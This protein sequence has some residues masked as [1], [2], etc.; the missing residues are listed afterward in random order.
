MRRPL[1]LTA[2]LLGFVATVQ[3]G[4]RT[5][6]NPY[7]HQFGA[8]GKLVLELKE[9][10]KHP[11]FWW[12]R[13]LLDY[14]VD[15]TG[16]GVEPGQLELVNRADGKPVPF[17][18]SD[19]QSKG[20]LLTSAMVSFFSDLPSGASRSFELRKTTSKKEPAPADGVRIDE[21]PDAVVVD[22]GA[23]KVRIPASQPLT[24]GAGVPGPLAA[25]GDT[26][27]W[28][29]QATLISPHKKVQTITTRILDRGPLFARVEVTYSFEGGATYT[30]TIRA[31]LGYDF[32]EFFEQIDGLAKE[33]NVFVE[34]DWKGFHATHRQGGKPIDKPYTL[35]FRGE[36]P[37]FTGPA[38]IENPAEDFYYRL[39]PNAADGTISVKN[40]DFTDAKSGRGIG[41]AVLDAYKWN[42]REYAIW[43]AGDAQAVRFRYA[44]GRLVWRWPIVSGTRDTA[45]LAYD[46]RALNTGPAGTATDLEPSGKS[47]SNY[48]AFVNSR[49][50]GMSLNLV[51]DWQLS[52]PDGAKLPAPVELPSRGGKPMESADAYLKALWSDSEPLKAEGN[53]VHP[54]GLRIMNYWVV[55]GFNKWRSKMSPEDRERVTALLLLTSYIA[56]RDETS[57]IVFRLGGHPNF[58]GDWKYPLMAGSFLFPDHPLANEWADQFEKTLEVMG[59]FYSRPEVK[60]W[61]AKGGR[62]TESIA[63]YNWAFIEPM[64]LANQLG[65]LFDGRDRWPNPGLARHGEYLYGITT[66]PVKL[67]KNGVPL[68]VA[69]G[70]ELT[71]ENGFQRIHPAQGA[72][73]GRRAI[74]RTLG[75]FGESLLRYRPLAGEYLLWA[76]QRPV[77]PAPAES[78]NDHSQIVGRDIPNKGTNPR[79]ASEKFT[80]YGI[81][82]R[83]AVDTP[84]EISVFLQQIDKGPNYRWGFGNEG[85]CG[86]IYYY[87]GGKSYA[88][89]FGED[90]GDR[91]VSDAELTANTGVYRDYTFKGIGM[92]DLTEPFYNLGTAQFAEI[93]PRQGPD[94]YSWPEYGGRSVLLAG[95]DYI[96]TYDVLNTQSR[97]AWNTIQG[98]DEKPTIIPLRG[99]NAYRINLTSK[100]KEDTA[101]ADRI[102]CYKGVSDRMLVVSHRK[103]LKAVLPG[104]DDPKAPPK[105]LTPESTDFIFQN[106]ENF[107]YAGQGLA[108]A[109]RAGLIRQKKDGRT[110]FA[111]FHGSLIGTDALKVSVDNPDLGISASFSKPDE[112]EGTFFSRKGGTLTLAFAQQVP[113]KTALYVD[114]KALASKRD[115]ETLTAELPAGKH[116]W[117]FTAGPA[118]PSTPQILNTIA[119]AGGATLVLPP[120]A[121]GQIHIIERSDDNGKTWTEAGR[122]ASQEFVLKGVKAPSKLHVR[123]VTLNLADPKNPRASLPGHDYPVYVT[124]KPPEPPEG[125]RLVLEKDAVHATWGEILGAKEYVLK[126]RVKGEDAWKQVH[127]TAG[128]GFT[129]SASGVVPSSAVP[130]LQAAASANSAPPETIYEYAVAAVDGNGEGPL[131]KIA[132][133]DPSSWRNWNPATPLVFKRQSAYWQPPYVRPDQVPPPAYPE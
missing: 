83:S 40:A 118:R 16:A 72:H 109:G 98:Q 20:G 65:I 85:G 58:M 78:E 42:D 30:G 53:W 18:L 57:P 60:S 28:L 130:G 93:L 12:P 116:D 37:F 90:T 35:F 69:S 33:D 7:I 119:Q 102:D 92:N 112:V 75:D 70:T 51:K 45:V 68:D 41:I 77:R 127:R 124:G 23:I 9:R 67:G 115:G 99:E 82:L 120:A 94:A 95:S 24:P 1:L 8:D 103:D 4:P 62:W 5:T 89:H 13:T 108:F 2:C 101:D 100:Q 107:D 3:T 44:D 6:S 55:P 128:T 15:F 48:T 73:G 66:A 117:E 81:I 123:P 87:A 19:V 54:V 25:I 64:T 39:L 63:V 31:P 27:G 88:G 113:E 133:T 38:R 132:D 111:L 80:G 10:I 79:L 71:A 49:Y 129:D 32:I 61:E 50:G 126:R 43:T 59:V 56:A 91:R 110:E 105:V 52:Y 34:M 106:R 22:T 86:D 104:K 21:K 14:R 17:Q 36:D 131:S 125:L 84:N 114:G 96:V 122:T 97:T 76:N 29:E 26:N 74:P 121:P 11:H 46:T 47:Q